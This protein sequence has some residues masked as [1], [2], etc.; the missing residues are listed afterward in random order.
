MPLFQEPSIERT[1]QLAKAAISKATALRSSGKVIEEVPVALP[2]LQSMN[3]ALQQFLTPLLKHYRIQWAKAASSAR[4]GKPSERKKVGVYY[5]NETDPAQPYRD[6]I[7]YVDRKFDEM[8]D[9][10]HNLLRYAFIAAAKERDS[11]PSISTRIP[12]AGLIGLCDSL[13]ERVQ[14]SPATGSSTARS[15]A[16]KILSKS[17]SE[18]VKE[19]SRFMEVLLT[20]CRYLNEYEADNTIPRHLLR[21]IPPEPQI[22]NTDAPK[23][24]PAYRYRV[25]GLRR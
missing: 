25:T 5:R 3:E 14:S 16:K 2:L 9:E 22:T 17:E 19:A 13:L 1:E 12:S 7:R 18:A 23:T 4:S 21:D 8:G 6:A 11:G 20:A 15:L 10:Y 24:P